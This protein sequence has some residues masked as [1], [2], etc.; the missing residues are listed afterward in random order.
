MYSPYYAV[1][2]AHLR[3]LLILTRLY[4]YIGWHT[5]IKIRDM[6]HPLSSADKKLWFNS[7]SMLCEVSDQLCLDPLLSF[8]SPV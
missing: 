4:Y 1:C 3:Y 6:P 7:F 2:I 5:F 8:R